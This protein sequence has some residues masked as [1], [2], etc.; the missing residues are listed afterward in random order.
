MSLLFRM[1][2]LT[3]SVTIYEICIYEI[4]FHKYMINNLED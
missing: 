4:G 1:L 3:T 2:G